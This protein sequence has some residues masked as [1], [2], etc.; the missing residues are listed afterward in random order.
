MPSATDIQGWISAQ[1]ECEHLDVYG[2]DEIHFEA[3]IVSSAFVGKSLVQRHQMVYATL[4]ERMQVEI[5]AL[6]MKTL[7]PDEWQAHQ[8]NNA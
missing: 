8:S 4:G 7:T 3:L 5:H 2:P 6:A 1:L